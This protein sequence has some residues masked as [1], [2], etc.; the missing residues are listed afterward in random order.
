VLIIP[1]P[2]MRIHQNIISLLDQA[3]LLCCFNLII[4]IFICVK[5]NKSNNL[6][7]VLNCNGWSNRWERM[8]LF[9]GYC[10]MF[11]EEGP[12]AGGGVPLKYSQSQDIFRPGRGYTDM[13][14]EG[15]G[16][17]WTHTTLLPHFLPRPRC[18]FSAQKSINF[19]MKYSIFLLQILE[20]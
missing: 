17:I 16:P 10:H 18:K 20:I 13:T 14:D 9:A 5:K 8:G 1:G 4:E 19:S 2:F 11:G 3:K 7:V 12:F 6:K 15:Q